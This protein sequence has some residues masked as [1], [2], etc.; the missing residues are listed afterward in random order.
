[1]KYC[2][3][4]DC[5][6][7][8]LNEV[9]WAIVSPLID[10]MASMRKDYREQ[11]GGTIKEAQFAVGAR[12]LEEFNRISGFNETNYLAIFHHRR[13]IFGKEC[14]SCGLLLRTPRASF[15]ANCGC[16]SDQNDQA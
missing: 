3:R 16:Y 7:P 11:N 13:S 15:C 14:S 10:N 8:L 1:M 4:C 6:V 12:L 9:E 5:E 2:W